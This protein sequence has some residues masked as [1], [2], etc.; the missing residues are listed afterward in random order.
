[1]TNGLGAILRSPLTGYQGDRSATEWLFA[2]VISHLQLDHQSA[3]QTN[4]HALLQWFGRFPG[5]QR[6]RLAS[7][8]AFT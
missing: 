7:A 5:P 8:Q 3:A 2:A 1:M 6:V 4:L